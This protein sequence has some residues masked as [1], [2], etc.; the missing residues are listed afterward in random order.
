[1]PIHE[2]NAG[3]RNPAGSIRGFGSKL[4]AAALA[5]VAALHLSGCTKDPAQAA[6]ESDAYGFQCLKCQAKFFTD[7]KSPLGSKCPKCQ[8]DYIE[9]VIGYWCE[10]DK[11]MT[12]RPKISG[13]GGAAVCDKCGG[14]LK[15]AMISPQQQDLLAW[16]ATKP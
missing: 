4:L 1:M 7:R 13:P 14:S 5:V 16:G 11:L 8:Q 2:C 10:K 15:N 6:I 12:I 9:D 3:P